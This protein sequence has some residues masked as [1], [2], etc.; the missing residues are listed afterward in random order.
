MNSGASSTGRP[1]GQV[2]TASPSRH[3]APSPKTPLSLAPLSLSPADYG[4]LGLDSNL[5]DLS[6]GVLAALS[7]IPCDVAAGERGPD[8][9]TAPKAPR[10]RPPQAPDQP[11]PDRPHQTATTAPG[12]HRK[13]ERR[14]GGT[15]EGGPGGRGK[16]R[17]GS[18]ECPRR[19]WTL[20]GRTI[21][22]LNRD[23]SAVKA[24]HHRVGYVHRTDASG[25]LGWAWLGSRR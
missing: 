15:R 1:N 23:S 20:G 5:I 25:L 21:R 11:A 16:V 13:R 9:K 6:C 14:G 12:P 7:L 10:T 4:A 18:W 2:L 19:P 17:G 22:H 3:F 24:G 8:S